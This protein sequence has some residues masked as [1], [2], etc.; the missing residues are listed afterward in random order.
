[1]PRLTNPQ[2]AILNAAENRKGGFILPLPMSIKNHGVTLQALRKKGLVTEK[3]GRRKTLVITEA[4][5]R[6]IRVGS[7]QKSIGRT[8][9]NLP[10][11]NM[12]GEEAK[13]APGDSQLGR[14]ASPQRSQ[15]TTKQALLI[16]LLA[17]KNGAT[18]SEAVEVTGWQP[19]SI[20]GAISGTLKKKLGLDVIS[21]K[22]QGG[23]RVYQI[24]D[25]S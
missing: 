13:H 7:D 16:E 22:V 11:Q 17:R 9:P 15:P 24:V 14:R 10:R 6:A 25:R 4:G 3:R 19:H 12:R 1:M 20:R 23:N 21:Q 18:I 5:S 2:R 8:Q